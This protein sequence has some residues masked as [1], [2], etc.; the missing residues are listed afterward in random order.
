MTVDRE[1]RAPPFLRLSGLVACRREEEARH[2]TVA[3]EI[4]RDLEWH[5]LKRRR[6]HEHPTPRPSLV[7]VFYVPVRTRTRTCASA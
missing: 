7:Q 4:A 1:T 5:E 6:P 3:S 2:P